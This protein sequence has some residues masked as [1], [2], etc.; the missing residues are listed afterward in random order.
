MVHF[1]EKGAYS[2]LAHCPYPNYTYALAKAGFA[3]KEVW[4]IPELEGNQ[5][6][7]AR[8][9]MLVENY[10]DIPVVI[11]GFEGG[12]G[13]SP[14]V[15]LSIADLD[16]IRAVAN[17]TAIRIPELISWYMERHINNPV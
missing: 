8:I 12:N 1:A 11:D 17:V 15:M 6:L 10:T 2:D 14:N 5:N 16:R 3:G 9:E 13:L 7:T 4:V